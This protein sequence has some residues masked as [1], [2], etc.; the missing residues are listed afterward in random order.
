MF[1]AGRGGMEIQISGQQQGN[2]A[3]TARLRTVVV[4]LGGSQLTDEWK[5]RA[6]ALHLLAVQG[7]LH[8]KY[9]LSTSKNRKVEEVAQHNQLKNFHEDAQY[10]QLKNFQQKS[11]CVVLASKVE[12]DKY[13]P[14]NAF[15][16][17]V[18]NEEMEIVDSAHGLHPQQVDKYF[19]VNSKKET[20]PFYVPNKHIAGSFNE[21]LNSKEQQDAFFTPGTAPFTPKGVK[22]S[23]KKH[24]TSIVAAT[25]VQVQA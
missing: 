3:A 24:I 22:G 25:E 19:V 9:K 15:T 5:L 8:A 23:F 20:A 18:N 2:A 13:I 21:V 1:G 17:L 16:V 6:A 14:Q 4:P 12:D 10:I 11:C 7:K